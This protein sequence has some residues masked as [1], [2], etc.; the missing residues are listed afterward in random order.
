MTAPRILFVCLGNICRSPMAEAALR[1]LRPDLTID[2]AG[3]GNWHI[4]APPHLPMQRAAARRGYDLG[5]LRA[6]Q[7]TVDDFDAFDLILAMDDQ[8]LAAI[9]ALRPAGNDTPARLLMGYAPQ[10]GHAHVP[11]PYYTGDYDLAI[12]LIEAA[13]RALDAQLSVT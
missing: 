12:D 7:M 8:N 13:T 6:R 2:S 10:S 4:G 11:D 9:E 5:A 3:T 1:H